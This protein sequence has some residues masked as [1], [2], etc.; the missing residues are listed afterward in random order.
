VD[1]DLGIEELLIQLSEVCNKFE[2]GGLSEK[3]EALKLLLKVSPNYKLRKRS[4]A[5]L[6]GALSVLDSITSV[7]DIRIIFDENNNPLAL[8]PLLILRLNLK[9]QNNKE[10]SFV[11]Q[12]DELALKD[13]IKKLEQ[14]LKSLGDIRPETIAEVRFISASSIKTG[15]QSES[16]VKE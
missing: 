5:Y 8:A 9:D 10:E 4:S 6:R 3:E 13:L 2:L 14:A 11:F 7:Q 16:K 1:G 12:L 15:D